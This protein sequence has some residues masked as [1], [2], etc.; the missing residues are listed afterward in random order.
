MGLVLKLYETGWLASHERW[1]RSDLRGE[2]Q[3]CFWMYFQLSKQKIP[4]LL[5]QKWQSNIDRDQTPVVPWIWKI[6]NLI[7]PKRDIA[8]SPI[9]SAVWIQQQPSVCK[10][11]QQRVQR[12]QLL[13]QLAQNAQGYVC[14]R[15]QRAHQDTGP[16]CESWRQVRENVFGRIYAENIAVLKYH[17]VLKVPC[18]QVV[19]LFNSSRFFSTQ[20]PLLHVFLTF[21]QQ[22][23]RYF[24][25]ILT[26]T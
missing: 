26:I 17:V 16:A 10:L 23:E 3:R 15:I 1:I 18:C 20:F 25:Y 8:S 9:V 7:C 2:Q 14:L 22:F 19:V 5:L 4:V 24:L 12:A 11:R 13:R 6:E 21:L